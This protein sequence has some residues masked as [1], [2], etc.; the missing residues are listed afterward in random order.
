M[1]KINNVIFVHAGI[2]INDTRYIN[3]DT[4]SELNNFINNSENHSID[5]QADFSLKF[6]K[7][8]IDCSNC[9]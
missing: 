4:V 9:Y 8:L 3:I 6:L 5:K 1:I 7:F 2:D